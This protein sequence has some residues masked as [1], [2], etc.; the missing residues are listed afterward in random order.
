[1]NEFHYP[2]F[3]LAIEYLLDENG[4]GRSL[5]DMRNLITDV[6]EGSTFA[7]AFETRVGM[8]LDDYEAGFFDLM[9]SYLPQ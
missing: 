2:I 9:D 7:A 8:S 4:G 5:E 6:S 3:R 1:M